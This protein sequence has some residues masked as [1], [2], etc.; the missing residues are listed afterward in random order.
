[1]VVAV[2][3]LGTEDPDEFIRAVLRFAT[4]RHGITRVEVE[5]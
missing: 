3:M 1:M 2:L 4:T 5:P